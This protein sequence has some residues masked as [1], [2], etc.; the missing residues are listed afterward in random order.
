MEET[1]FRSRSRQAA[2]QVMYQLDLVGGGSKDGAYGEALK[3][4][5]SELALD[6]VTMNYAEHL[7][8]GTIEKSEEIDAAIAAASKNWT[9]DRMGVVERSILRLAAFELIFCDNKD[10]P[11]KVA[12]D[13]ALELVRRFGSEDSVPFVN[14]ILDNIASENN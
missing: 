9:I 14:G 5:C 7:L 4:I 8:K 11:Y 13:E 1:N 6:E 2:L 3:V 10:V 12:I